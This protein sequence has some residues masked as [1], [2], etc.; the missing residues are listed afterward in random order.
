MRLLTNQE[1]NQQLW[2]ASLLERPDHHFLQ[3]WAWG[4]FQEKIGN[5]IWRIAVE[6]QGTLLLQ[7]LVIK[8]SLGFGQSIL[9]SPRGQLVPKHLPA[10]TLDQASQLILQSVK[11]LAQ[12]EN[13][14][15]FRI[16]PPTLHDDITALAFYRS[17]GFVANPKK[18]IQPQHNQIL[19]LRRGL[20][21]ALSEAKSKTRY[22][23][24]VARRDPSKLSSVISTEEIDIKNFLDLTHK[25][26]SRQGFSSHSDNY[27]RT[28]ID[29]LNRAGMM[30][31]LS[32]RAADKVVSSVAVIFFGKTATYVHGA[33]DEN[34]RSLMAPYLLHY[35][36]LKL[37]EEKG[38]DFY[39]LGGVQP[40][41]SHKWA[42]ITRF[43]QGFGG[44][45]IKYVGTLELPIN[46]LLYKMYRFIDLLR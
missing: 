44:T 26:A 24:N 27:Y 35:E 31:L 16:D 28:Q 5:P 15:F 14:I 20:N 3:S 7:L 10:Q 25:T 21:A 11:K 13:C 22:N 43:K 46:P 42:G 32:A 18:P 9:Y 34:Y 45:T 37:A 41:P 19:D 33:S 1:L 17:Q 29:I 23:I 39:D 38:M 8:Q 36:A 12:K 2:D 40:D 4:E 6:D 30:D